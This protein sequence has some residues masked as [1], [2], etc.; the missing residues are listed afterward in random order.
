LKSK[1]WVSGTGQKFLD[2]SWPIECVLSDLKLKV[3]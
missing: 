3:N 1:T 2:L